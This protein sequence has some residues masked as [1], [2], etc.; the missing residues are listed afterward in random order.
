MFK[1]DYLVIV[2]SGSMYILKFE[3]TKQGTEKSNVRVDQFLNKS[4][5]SD[6]KEEPL[7]GIG[8]V[9]ADAV[10]NFY[11]NQEKEYKIEEKHL[12]GA[13]GKKLIFRGGGISTKITLVAECEKIYT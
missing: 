8:E 10:T 12:K 5:L 3:N 1:K 2:E 6:K 13:V 9:L 4:S 11:D 7:L